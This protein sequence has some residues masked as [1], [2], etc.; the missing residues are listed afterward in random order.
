MSAQ[1]ERFAKVL[2]LPTAHSLPEFSDE[3]L[4]LEFADLHVCDLRYVASWQQWLRWDGA[5]W[6]RDTTLRAYS[7][8]REICRAVSSRCNQQTQAKAIASAHTVAAVEKL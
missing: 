5:R 3:A 1:G 2:Q 4:A 7:L 8:S 6:K